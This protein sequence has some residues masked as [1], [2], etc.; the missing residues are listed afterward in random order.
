MDGTNQLQKNVGVDCIAPADPSVSN[1]DEVMRTD[2]SSMGDVVSR[3]QGVSF[4]RTP[5]SGCLHSESD[6]TCA[7]H[8]SFGS[9]YD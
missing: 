7:A 5:K 1:Y 2:C 6:N 8:A 3:E 9:Q 4:R